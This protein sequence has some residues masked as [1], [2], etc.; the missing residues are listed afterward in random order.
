MPNEPDEDGGISLC[1]EGTSCWFNLSENESS[2]IQFFCGYAKKADLKK[3]NDWNANVKYGKSYINEH[4][5]SL[6]IDLD[7]DGGV[8][9]GRLKDFIKTCKILLALW[10]R[11]VIRD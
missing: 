1:I 8:T 10:E 6:E 5:T 3:V 9:E 2:D 4:G 7:L 11:D